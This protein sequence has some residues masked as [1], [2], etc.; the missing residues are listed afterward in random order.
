MC[1]EPRNGL[2]HVFMPPVATTEDYLDLVG[3]HRDIRHR[4][5]DAGR[6]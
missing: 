3:R 6:H 1:I 5:G 2:L 4:T